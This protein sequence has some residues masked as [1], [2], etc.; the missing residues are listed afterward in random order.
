MTEFQPEDTRPTPTEAPYGAVPYPGTPDPQGQP[1]DPRRSYGQQ[2]PAYGQAPPPAPAYGQPAPMAAPA[3]GQAP[4]PA[5]AYGQPAPMAA[6]AYGQAPPL[7]LPYGQPAPMASPPQNPAWGAAPPAWNSAPAKKRKAWPWVVGGIGAVAVLGVGAIVTVLFIG[8]AAVDGLNPDYGAPAVTQQDVATGGGTLIV[9]DGADSAFEIDPTWIDQ[10]DLV[11]GA[12]DLSG[13]ASL[14]YIGAW[15]TAV[16]TD[17]QDVSLVTV[18]V[19]KESI[20]LIS[21]TLSAEHESSVKGF[22]N[23]FADQ[24][25]NVQVS[26]AT[27]ATTASGLA[28]LHS[29]FS[30]DLQGLTVA[31]DLYTFARGKNFFLLQ[32]TSYNGVPDE[33]SVNQILDTVRVD[34]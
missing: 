30:A 19:G 6:P 24:A 17:G 12:T 9:A 1:F 21:A 31:G 29:T 7:P 22:V 25:D 8:K 23:G 3:Y 13:E 34:S 16:L 33:A 28:G 5:P 11:L 20:P 2:S 14:S 26:D 32:V 27:P 15:S 10:K 18:I 4:P